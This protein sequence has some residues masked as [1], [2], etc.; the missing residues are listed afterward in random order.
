M[1]VK[2]QLYFWYHL[3]AQYAKL[4]NIFLFFLLVWL[5]FDQIVV[6]VQANDRVSFG[7]RYRL[8]N[9]VMP[10]TCTPRLQQLMW[11]WHNSCRPQPYKSG[12]TSSIQCCSGRFILPRLSASIIYHLPQ[13]SHVHPVMLIP[14]IC[15]KPNSITISVFF[16][17]R[18]HASLSNTLQRHFWYLTCPL[19]LF[20]GT[21]RQLVFCEVFRT[22]LQ[23][24]LKFLSPS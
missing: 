7:Q 11:E 12:T 21:V 1:F 8:P 13:L 3:N 2:L 14:L 10:K 18:F 22:V 15:I 16:I 6:A 24:A 9:T 17:L 5:D 4:L 20:S 19:V 23:R